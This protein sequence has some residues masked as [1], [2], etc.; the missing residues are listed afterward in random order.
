MEY[1]FDAKRDKK[2]WNGEDMYGHQYSVMDKP[3]EAL[4][5][6]F[7]DMKKAYI[8]ARNANTEI[9]I[10]DYGQ[11]EGIKIMNDRYP[12]PVNIDEL[13]NQAKILANKYEINAITKSGP[14][15]NVI[16][17]IVKIPNVRIRC[18]TYI[19]LGD[20]YVWFRK[21]GMNDMK[22]HIYQAFPN[23]ET[24]VNG[25]EADYRTYGNSSY[26]HPHIAGSNPCLGSFEAPIKTC[27]GHF[28]IVGVINNVKSYLHAYYYRSVYQKGS[29]YKS[30]NTA[31]PSLDMIDKYPGKKFTFENFMQ[32]TDIWKSK[33]GDMSTEEYDE[34]RDIWKAEWFDNKHTLELQ[35]NIGWYYSRVLDDSSGNGHWI[36]NE[37]AMKVLLVMK[38][39]KLDDYWTAYAALHRHCLLNCPTKSVINKMPQDYIDA[40]NIMWE[41]IWNRSERS[42]NVGFANNRVRP[43]ETDSN[44]VDKFNKI[45]NIIHPSRNEMWNNVRESTCIDFYE[46]LKSYKNELEFFTPNEDAENNRLFIAKKMIDNLYPKYMD[47][48]QSYAR[49]IIIILNKEK[50]RLSNGLNYTKPSAE[51]GQLSFET[52]SEDRVV[53]S[54]V[55]SDDNPR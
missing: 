24:F 39:F 45:M 47:W 29:Y 3:L 5:I 10:E 12:N 17:F 43:D 40:Y 32:H 35:P 50:R 6:C 51:S 55:V 53:G 2:V 13:A 15:N 30:L 31:T 49:K 36:E 19:N 38:R 34:A 41:H 46:G 23:W 9:F 16:G 25:N 54:S 8:N 4:Q 44:M 20:Y 48:R 1:T 14:A 22:L 7:D 37:V 27:A 42:Y 33:G 21:W 11:E 28:N 52:L 18:R 26:P